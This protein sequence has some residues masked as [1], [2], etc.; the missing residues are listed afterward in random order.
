MEI[1]R[2]LEELAW[3][4]SFLN[5]QQE[6]L[7]PSLF[8]ITWGRHLNMRNSLHFTHDVPELSTVNPDLR[9]EGSVMVTSASG[10]KPKKK[11]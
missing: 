11:P 1:R 3:V 8:M 7:S 4:E 2:E 5:Y 10:S 9:L 6:V